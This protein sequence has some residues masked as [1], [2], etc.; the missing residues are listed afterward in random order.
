MLNNAEAFFQLSGNCVNY[1]LSV[2]ILV[3]NT[4]IRLVA[5]VVI[6]LICCIIFS[7]KNLVSPQ[8]FIVN[9]PI[10]LLIV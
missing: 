2:Q 4:F 5:K 9:R 6:I 7:R 10:S 3:F 1:S 8:N